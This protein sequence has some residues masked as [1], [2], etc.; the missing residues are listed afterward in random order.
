MNFDSNIQ[1]AEVML[2]HTMKV[3]F[4]DLHDQFKNDKAFIIMTSKI[5]EVLEIELV[6]LYV[7][8]LAGPMIT[9]R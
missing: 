8:R 1:R 9:V 4:P 3:Q 7:K 5:G 2:M 6:E